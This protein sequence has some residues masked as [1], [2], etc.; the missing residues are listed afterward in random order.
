MN[1][2]K[3]ENYHASDLKASIIDVASK[4]LISDGIE[5]ITMRAIASKLGV[6]RGAPY[7]HFVDKHDLLCSV[8][9]HSFELLNASMLNFS[10]IGTPP[11]DEF[12]ELT[13]KYID[14][15]LSYPAFYH[16]MFSNEELL[17]NQTTELSTS[18]NKSFHKLETLLEKLQQEGMTKNEDLNLQ[19]NY[20]WSSLHG[21]C[22]L[23]LA[24]ETKKA[25]KLAKNQDFFLEKIWCSLSTSC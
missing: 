12:H 14:F 17:K 15:C 5:A 25:E 20:V 11:K 8:A 2:K 22:C 21:Y 7:R 4:L 1:T 19:A 3:Y 6:S 13:K 9:Q 24:Q 10:Q 18:A 16:L 23:L